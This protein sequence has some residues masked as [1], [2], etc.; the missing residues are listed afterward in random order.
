MFM[1]LCA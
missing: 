1:E